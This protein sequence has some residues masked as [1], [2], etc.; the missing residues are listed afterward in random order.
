MGI[1]SKIIQN[2]QKSRHR[3]LTDFAHPFCPYFAENFHR[4][5]HNFGRRFCP[6]FSQ[7]PL[8]LKGYFKV[9]RAIFPPLFTPKFFSPK[10]S[11]TPPHLR[12][13]SSRRPAPTPQC[14]SFVIRPAPNATASSSAISAQT[15]RIC[16][17]TSIEDTRGK[18]RRA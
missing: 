17:K 3:P 11:R 1:I 5:M 2:F 9:A 7:K 14:R 8:Q 6:R 13:H 12:S 18:R 15:G 10:H 16:I 4:F